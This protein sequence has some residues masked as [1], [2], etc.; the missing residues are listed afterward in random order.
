MVERLGEI[1]VRKQMLKADDL[2]RALQEQAE[3]GQFLGEILIRLG[4][5]TEED[6]LKVL[7]E[8]FNTRFVFLKDVRLNP[9]VLK[10]VPKALAWEHKVLPIEMRGGVLLIAM[11]N[12]LD[13]WPISVIQEKLTL[14]DVQFVLAKKDDIVEHLKKY[15]GP[16]VR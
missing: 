16:E 13:M 2:D 8:Q 14:V 1:L 12:P 9:A 3:S 7:A 15:Y 5:V 10:V 6:I 4:Y 11:A